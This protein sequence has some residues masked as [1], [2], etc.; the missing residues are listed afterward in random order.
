VFETLPLPADVEVVGPVIARLW[1]STSA[2]DTDFTIK[3]VDVHP[4]SPD[5]PEGFAM[6]LTD[7][8]LRLRFRESFETPRL[9]EPGRVYPIE[10]VAFPTANC[11]LAGHRIRLD[12]ASSN[13]PHFDLN[14]NTGVPAGEPS[15]PRIAINRVHLGPEHPSQLLLS[16]MPVPAP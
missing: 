6:N 12:V 10:I 16:M 5:W 8:I 15:E 14:P 11:F 2:P 13:F 1:V 3:L 9:A 7:G 4:P